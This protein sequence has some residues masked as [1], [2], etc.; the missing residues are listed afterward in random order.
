MKT[1]E[2]IEQLA[3]DYALSIYGYSNLNHNAYLDC[4]RHCIEFYTQCQKD[5]A[6]KWIKTSEKLPE[7]LPN[8][9]YSNPKV[10]VWYKGEVAMLCF[11][12]E[13]ECWDDE[14]GDDYCCDI[15]SVEYWM[16]LPNKPL[17]K[18]D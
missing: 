1:K 5:M 18:Q 13:H 8:V 12:H 7:R 9:K 2:E 11:N 10:I 14:G 3:D 4:K 6:D 16:P 17:N 15:E